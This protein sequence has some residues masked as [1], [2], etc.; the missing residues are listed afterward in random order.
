MRSERPGSALTAATAN[1]NRWVKSLPWRVKSRTPEPSQRARDPKT[2]VLDLVLP[3]RSGRRALGGKRQARFN[4]AE[5][6]A[7]T[8]TQHNSGPYSAGVAECKVAFVAYDATQLA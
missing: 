7:G 6:A 1:G 5:T 8:Q 4:E 2:I 3:A